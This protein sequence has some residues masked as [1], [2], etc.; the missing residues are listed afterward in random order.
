MARDDE[1]HLNASSLTENC[2][3]YDECMEL[4]GRE[5]A[6]GGNKNVRRH[7]S[8]CHLPYYVCDHF[9]STAHRS[10]PPSFRPDHLAA[11]LRGRNQILLTCPGS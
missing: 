7:P 9:G 6:V 2:L 10:H 3:L 8:L 4:A 5:N 1:E 11:T